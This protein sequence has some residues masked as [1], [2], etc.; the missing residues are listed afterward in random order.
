[1][2]NTEGTLVEQSYIRLD[3][4]KNTMAKTTEVS[5]ALESIK[6]KYDITSIFIEENLQMFRPGLSSAKVLITL[7]RFNGMVTLMSYKVFGIEPEFLN[8]NAARKL[9]GLKIDRKDKSKTTKEKVLEWVDDE[10]GQSFNWPTKTLKSGPRKGTEVYESGCYDIA[11]AHVI[12]L[13][14]QKLLNN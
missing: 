8:V 9:V 5:S 13:A 3:K 10:L 14:G 7:A 6:E 1:V 4:I 2:L 11:D 12:A